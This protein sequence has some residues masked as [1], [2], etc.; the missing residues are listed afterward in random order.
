MSFDAESFDSD[1]EASPPRRPLRRAARAVA[2]GVLDL[3]LPP[4]CLACR[5]AVAT[6]GALCAGCWSRLAFIERPYCERL[7]TPFAFDPGGALL[8]P[9]AMDAAPA[10]QRA[11][12]A[13][14]FGEVAR[15][16]VHALKYGDRLEAAAPMAR[17]MARAGAELLAQADAVVPV[18]LHPM[19]LWR[20]RFN[21]S[22]A[23]G[24]VLAKEAGVA[25]RPDWL[26]RARATPP[27]VGLNRTA[28]A[29]NV[30]GA[31]AVPEALRTELR[32]RR[33]VL[34]D[35]VLT[36]GATLDACTKTLSRAG[37][38][39][40]DVLVFARVVDGTPSTLS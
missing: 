18:P 12:A 34:V 37:A 6:P 10:Y 32:G 19:R 23:L 38:A 24:R 25:F 16:M 29:A 13:V 20:R 39:G 36:T 9:E 31:F 22:A 11:R 2:F 14:T 33:V 28:R 30:A 26:V 4:S 35:D 7:G 17:M 1:I 15:A 3:L 5:G 21:Q 27:Q 40:I 8:S